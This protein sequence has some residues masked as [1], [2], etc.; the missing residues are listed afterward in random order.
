[1]TDPFLIS[2]P[3]IISFSGGRTSGYMLRRILDACGG[4]LPPDVYACFANTGKE[5]PETLN[6]VDDVD[7]EWGVGVRWLEYRRA[8]HSCDRWRE[9]DYASAS[10]LGEPFSALIEERK[11]LPNPIMRYCTQSLK[12]QAIRNFAWYL[13]WDSWTAVVGLRAD[14]PRRVARL[15][16]SREDSSDKIAPL[17][18]AGITKHDVGA[19]WRVQPF[20]LHLPNVDGSTPMGNCDLCFLKG[21]ARLQR[22]MQERPESSAWWID[23]ERKAAERDAE[24]KS[25][26]APGRSALNFRKDRPSYAAMADNVRRQIRLDIGG[27]ADQQ[28]DCMCSEDQ[29]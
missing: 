14:E 5:M 16:D 10:R 29:S 13:G 9:V 1:M 6:F 23:E 28:V 27:D 17:A 24:R 25:D 12:I 22:I 4:E 15:S 3:A 7:R 11:I 2:G 18:K 20:D 19:F 8:H 26:R 21:T